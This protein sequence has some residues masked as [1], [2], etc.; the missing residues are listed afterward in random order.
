ME[1][2][3]KTNTFVNAVL[4]FVI[5]FGIFIIL[6]SL[7]FLIDGEIGGFFGTAVTGLGLAGLAWAA[8]RI[9]IIPKDGGKPIDIGKIAG[10]IFGG[11]GTCMVIGSIL[12]LFDEDIEAAIGLF[13]FGCVFCGA[14]YLAYRIFRPPQGKKQVLVSERFQKFTGRYGEPG[15]RTSR[16]FVYVDENMSESEINKMQNEWTEKPWTQRKDWAAGKVIEEGAQN[17]GFLIVFTILWNLISN[18]ITAIA[19]ISEWEAGDVPWFMLIFPIVG[20]ILIIVTIRTWIRRR[21]FG[22]SIMKLDT[23]PAYLGDRLKATVETGVS[24]LDDPARS[25]NVKFLCAEKKS[26]RDREGKKRVSVREIWS[27]EHEVYGQL[28]ESMKT[29][30][31]SIY[32]N[33]PSDLPPTHL[34]PEDDRTLW[35][36]NVTSKVP[37]VDYAAQFEVPVYLHQSDRDE[38]Y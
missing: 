38:S 8:R 37:G 1:Q 19:F 4:W 14:G 22:I 18:G 32:F 25:F 26:T 17:L 29:F 33:V 16:Q 11:A 20:L 12:L 23:L 5:G 2:N 27:E 36:V 7:L 35:K 13:I 6:L 30:T 3:V 15:Q 24:A 31:I 34:I 28:S 21:K 9:F 10:I